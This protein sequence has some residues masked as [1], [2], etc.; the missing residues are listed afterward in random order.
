MIVE[1]E[2]RQNAGV[3]IR[4]QAVRSAVIARELN[5]ALPL[6]CRIDDVRVEGVHVVVD[7]RERAIELVA[8][9]EVDRQ[10]GGE[11]V[12]VLDIAG[13]VVQILV[14]DRVGGVDGRG[15][16]QAEFQVRETVAGLAGLRGERAG[17]VKLTREHTG[18]VVTVG[19]AHELAAN[20]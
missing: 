12:V 13:E 11:P 2:A 20:G 5:A 6:R 4:D 15:R 10:L 18:I 8:Q 9:T 17:E 3:H 1:A 16:S 7:L 19:I 14:E